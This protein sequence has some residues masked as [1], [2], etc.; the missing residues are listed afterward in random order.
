M[1]APATAPAELDFGARLARTP[2]PAAIVI[3]GASGD[4]TKRKLVPALYNLALQQL[5]PPETAIVGVARRDLSDD[6][7]RESM[8]EGV[9]LYSRTKADDPE[10]WDGF[11]RRLR[12][13]QLD[14]PDSEGYGRLAA[15]L[16]ELDRE[17][18]TSGNRL[19]YLATAPEHFAVIAS[20][21]GAAG[22]S[23]EGDGGEPFARLVIEKPFGSD[24]ASARQLNADLST[25]FRERQ[26]YRIDHYLGKETVQNLLVFRFGNSIFEPVWN[27]RY[28]DHVQIT[29][30]EEL[31]VESRGGYYDQS[32]AL[33]DIVQNHMMQ[34]LSIVAMEPPAR[35]ESRE[36][37]DEKV[38][39]LHAIPPFDAA[40]VRD[41]AVRAQYGPG[42]IGGRPV[43]GYRE[44]E[45]VAP[46]SIT[47]TFVAM[48]LEIDNWR[49]A[50]TPF[51]LR[52]GKRLPRRA[53][54]VA[55]SFK[56]APHLP[57]ASTAVEEVQPNLLVLRIQPEEGASLRFVAKVPGP[58]IDLRPVRMDFD[59]GTSFLR[60]SP[61]A[62][63]RL[64]LDCLL[65]DSTLFARWDEVERAWEI[66]EG[67]VESWAAGPDGMRTYEA[68]TWGPEAADRL[69]TP[70]GRTWRTL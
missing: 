31:G 25:V 36:V 34:V 57:F 59:Y 39:V 40:G 46:D 28:I 54:E 42:W 6:D 2:E 11:A 26:V 5:L 18:G 60:A 10:V 65:G 45:G 13:L 62:Y 17:G 12:Y 22:L 63:E 24:L 67:V 32:G 9:E 29:V 4:L 61:D 21:L 55:I 64:L 41:H 3:F 48:R 51:Y 20:R 70:D 14:F 68:G 43:P 30:A 50:N 19:F 23:A 33:R 47:E 58:Q 56:P 35:F 53:T 69:M 37:R 7:F 66:M 15:L 8:R 16:A 49:W 52:T 1:S 44:E 38:K 27:R